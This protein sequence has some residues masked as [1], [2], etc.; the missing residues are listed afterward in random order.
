MY[1]TTPRAFPNAPPDYLVPVTARNSSTPR[2]VQ[3][4]THSDYM[5]TRGTRRAHPAPAYA[6]NGLTN[7]KP[8]L[9]LPAYA[10]RPGGM[11]SLT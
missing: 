6:I 5:T 11:C 7:V 10:S 1:L 4:Q 2:S 3:D 8:N 9:C